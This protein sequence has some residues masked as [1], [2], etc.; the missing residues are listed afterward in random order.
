MPIS[1]KPG[2]AIDSRAMTET[3][4]DKLDNLFFVAFDN[5]T[6]KIYNSG[7]KVVYRVRTENT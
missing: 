7:F 6:A 3:D 2:F 5:G 4:A 1:L